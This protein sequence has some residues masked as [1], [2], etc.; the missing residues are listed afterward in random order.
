MTW[1]SR[2]AFSLSLFCLAAVRTSAAEPVNFGRDVLPILSDNCFRCHGPD[3]NAR[4]AKLRLDA[5][6]GALRKDR[7]IIVAGK[8]A[9]SELVRRVS[10][11]DASEVMPPPKSNRKLTATQIETLKRW[12]D[13]GAKWGRHW[14]FDP[15]RRPTLPAVRDGRWPRNGLD[16]F[17]L[18][19]LEAEG[20]TPS[21]EAPKETLLRRVTLDLTGL[22]PTPAEVDAFLADAAPGAYERV[23]DRLLASPHYGERMVWEWLDAARYADSNGYQGDGERTMW[24][25]RDW[26]VDALNRNL[27]FDQFTVWQL[28]GDLLPGATPEQKLA[29]AFCRNHPINGEG[30][31]IAEENRIDYVMDMAETTGTVWL[32]LTF[33]CC[34]CHDH[35]FDALTQRD[36]YSLFAFFNQTPV[37]GG[38]GDPRTPPVLEYKTKDVPPQAT[39]VGSRE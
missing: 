32:G 15:P 12:I 16:R 3:A 13:E 38:G 17:I 19:R 1:L 23:V 25:W 11:S 37:N 28:A 2:A 8:S 26:A 30:G 21:A 33:N 5:Q 9:D 14:A 18:A 35:K 29:T 24:P 4:K 6:D 39:A 10:S 27:P 7:P 34:R 20:L 31:R 36:Y 22:P